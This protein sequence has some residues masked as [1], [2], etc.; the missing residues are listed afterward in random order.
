M[1]LMVNL[2]ILFNNVNCNTD[3]RVS[4]GFRIR[5]DLGLPFQV[6]TGLCIIFPA[7]M[8]AWMFFMPRS[9]VFLITK[10]KMEEARKSLQF[11]RGKKANVEKELEQIEKDVKASENIG[12]I[13]PMKLF[14]TKEYA[15]P[16][17]ISMVLMFL[18]QL[19]GILFIYS[20]L[21]L[22]FEVIK[23]KKVKV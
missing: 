6:S 22:I 17:G 19:S 16:I 7:L 13:G 15:K 9:P 20:Y 18:Q 5:R 10:G 23:T 11:L 21:A 14:F 8:A 1:Q 12:S 3:W 4:S 2:G